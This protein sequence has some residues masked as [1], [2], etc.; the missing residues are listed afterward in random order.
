MGNGSADVGN[1]IPTL[2]PRRA[3]TK[4]PA[5]SGGAFEKR[6]VKPT[7]QMAQKTE[8]PKVCGAMTQ[9]CGDSSRSNESAPQKFL[10]LVGC[11]DPKAR[12]V[13]KARPRPATV[14]R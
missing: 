4:Q 7:D 2:K 6:N 14:K 8:K 9:Q 11:C 1:K 3:T 10:Q 13:S 12:P 5:E